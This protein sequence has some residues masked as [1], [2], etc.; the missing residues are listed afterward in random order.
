MPDILGPKAILAPVVALAAWTLI[1]MLWMY[2]TRIPALK[3][4]GISIGGLVGGRPG[5]LDDLLEPQVQWKAHNYNHLSEQ[6]TLFYAVAI[7]LCLLGHGGGLAL[8]AAW[9]YVLFRIGH[10]LVQATVNIVTWRFGLFLAASFCLIVLT[11]D[12]AV[13]LVRAALLG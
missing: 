4:A 6:P 5:G 11:V 13:V 7:S 2:A 3:R 9:L 1:V 12:A 8:L 10:S